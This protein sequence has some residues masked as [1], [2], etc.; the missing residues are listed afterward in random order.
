MQEEVCVCVSGNSD[1]DAG[2]LLK[3][4][5]NNGFDDTST[6]GRELPLFFVG[7]RKESV[8]PTK[9]KDYGRFCR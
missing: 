3:L 6:K 5:P 2:G 7:F 9:I 8:F 4:K 1:S